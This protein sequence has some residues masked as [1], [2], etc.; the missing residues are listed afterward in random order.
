M[1]PADAMKLYLEKSSKDDRLDYV[2]NEI[3][4]LYPR[5][6]GKG[7]ARNALKAAFK[8]H[9]EADIRV[10]IYDYVKT[11]DG[12]D[13]KYIPHLATWLNQER[14]ADEVAQ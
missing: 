10:A 13:P 14:W 6:V 4:D 1:N 8:K 3:W 11:L 7:A 9:D 2:F 12:Q 5:K